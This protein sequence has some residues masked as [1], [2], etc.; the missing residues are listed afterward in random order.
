MRKM[1]QAIQTGAQILMRRI[2]KDL[3]QDFDESEYLRANTDVAAAVKAGRIRSG[4]AHWL[5]S[6]RHE[7]RRLRLNPGEEEAPPDFSENGYLALHPEVADAVDRGIYQ[8]GLQ[9]WLQKGRFE[10]RAVF[11]SLPADFDEDVYLRSHP[12]LAKVSIS[13]AS[14]WLKYGWL[15][16]RRS[17]AKIDPA[18]IP[19][20]FDERGYLLSNPDVASAVEGYGFQSGSS[21]WLRVGRFEGRTWSRSSARPRR[22]SS[23]ASTSAG[24]AQS[25]FQARA[26]AKAYPDVVTHFGHDH[27]QL[28]NHWRAHGYKE[29]RTPFGFAPYKDRK[30]SQAHRGPRRAVN[31][32]GFLN[33]QS[34]LGR[35]A[36]GYLSALQT[37]GREVDAFAICGSGLGYE[38]SVYSRQQDGEPAKSSR[39][40]KINIFNINADMVHKFF[41]DQRLDLLDGSFNIGIWVWELAHFRQD[42]ASMFG[43]FDEIW[44]P[45]EFCRSAIAAVSP[46]PVY[47]VPHVVALDAPARPSS[48]SRLRIPERAYVFGCIFD[49]GSALERKNPQAVIRAFIEAFGD[50]SD[51]MLVVKYHSTRSHLDQIASLHKLA[52][53]GANIKFYGGT[54][55]DEEVVSFKSSLDCYVSAHRSEGFGLNIAESL[56]LGTPVIAT[57][58][59]GSCDFVDETSGFPVNYAMAEVGQQ[60]G[61][62]PPHALWAD[63]DAD[64]LVRKMRFAESSREEAL[65][66]ARAG[67]RS[68]QENNSVEAI[69]LRIRERLDRIDGSCG[70]DRK[71]A[72]EYTYFHYESNGPRISLVVPVYN[73][74]AEYLGK[75]INSVIAQSYNNWELVLHDDGSDRRETLDKLLTYKGIDHRIK[76]SMG[77]ANEGIAGATNAAIALTSGEFIAFL[78]DDDE[79]DPEALKEIAAAIAANP[80]ADLLYTDEDKIDPDGTFCDHYLKPDW[81]PEHLESTAYLLHMMVVRRS[82]LLEVGGLRAQYSGAQ[83]FDLSLRLSRVARRVVHVPKVLYHWRKIPGSAAA[84]VDAKP[85]GLQRAGEA[86]EDHL[87]AS[88]RQATVSPGLLPGLFR[89]RDVITKGL[90]VTLVIFTDNR[91]AD[92][93]GRGRINLFDHF[94]RSIFEKTKTA[95]DMRILAIDNSN[96]SEA[97]RKIIRSAG[98]S[99]VGYKGESPKFN[100]SSKVNFALAQ[101]KTELVVLLNDDMEIVSEDWLD[102]LI[103]LA[104]RPTTGV[105]GA[106]LL[107]TDDRIQHCGV[108]L[109]INGHPAH[110]FHQFPGDLV[111]Y[112]GY[113]HIIRNYLAVT[114]ACMATKMSLFDEI[115]GFDEAFAV[116]YNDTDFCLRAHVAGYRNI[117]TPHCTLYHF[118]GTTQN[119]SRPDPIE[120]KMFVTKWQNF[121]DADP[122]Y[123]PNLT[124]ER[125]D[126]SL[127]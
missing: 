22:R 112:N 114:G 28:L 65:S 8:T 122:F 53:G 19:A 87:A 103:E 116:D 99:V 100:F 10:N 57:N 69:G 92:V 9:H 67:Q 85:I 125:L 33:A 47:V 84:V 105:V 5:S 14:H 74:E 119:G 50:R 89:V 48:R 16:G 44:V 90:P 78:D 43:A 39:S 93:P 24:P 79:I 34:G 61:P 36:R 45:S 59:S 15:E 42:W 62:Y 3:P 73:I 101:V 81:S 26:Y 11:P 88:G 117:Y 52:A 118:E 123:N 13:G 41:L 127:R 37:S 121:M 82:V 32:F 55:S 110:M 46:V 83:D 96:L 111:G 35:A 104:Q 4:A 38:T 29:G 66:R 124:R 30:L 107:Y 20:D 23:A 68:I 1:A 31:F 56:L 76:I 75:C 108:N 63:P 21:H 54:W 109:G 106:R 80:G 51:V 64:D 115:G 6:G 71:R 97:Q 25:G 72:G 7:G 113:T 17:W 126:F 58:Y 86:L 18:E 94:V 91:S 70:A 12:D 27:D 120:H 102:A 95:C 60:I 40:N 49:V 98:G 2:A 77:S